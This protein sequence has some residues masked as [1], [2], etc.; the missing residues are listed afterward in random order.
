MTR[1]ISPSATCVQDCRTRIFQVKY[2][3]Q[4][5]NTGI[6]ERKPLI[7]VSYCIRFRLELKYFRFAQFLLDAHRAAQQP[8][9]SEN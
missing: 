5:Q 1:G 4:T 6:L 7:D 3:G 2:Q 9:K 8:R